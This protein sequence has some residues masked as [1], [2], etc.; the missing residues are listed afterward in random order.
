MER[1]GV[2]G[3][4]VPPFARDFNAV[5]RGEYNPNPGPRSGSP[6][7]SPGFGFVFIFAKDFVIF[8]QTQTIFEPKF[9]NML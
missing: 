3:T 2:G 8:N 9:C 5:I 1:R 6:W 4:L 7:R